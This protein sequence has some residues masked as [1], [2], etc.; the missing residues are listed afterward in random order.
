MIELTRTRRLTIAVIIF[1]LLIVIGFFT[2]KN[3]KY[4]YS[5]STQEMLNEMNDRNGQIEIKGIR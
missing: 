5:I 4:V 2:L 3:P 1:I